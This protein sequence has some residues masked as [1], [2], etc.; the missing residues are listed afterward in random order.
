MN[1]GSIIPRMM[2]RASRCESGWVFGRP[3]PERASASMGDH[4]NK[5]ARLVGRV[6]WAAGPWQRV[7]LI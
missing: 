3:M 7:A 4:D 2:I 5:A 6:T 1:T